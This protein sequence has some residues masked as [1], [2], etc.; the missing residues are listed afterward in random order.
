MAVGQFFR[1]VASRIP[2]PRAILRKAGGTDQPDARPAAAQGSTAT[3]KTALSITLA[4]ILC[5]MPASA[6]K[7]PPPSPQS[8]GRWS[9]GMNQGVIEA[10][11]AAPD[12]SRLSFTC[13]AG[14]EHPVAGIAVE[15]RGQ[16]PPGIAVLRLRLDGRSLPL[17]LEEGVGLAYGPMR[18]AVTEAADALVTSRARSVL[19]EL[20]DLDWRQDFPL[21]GVR[22]ALG[23]RPGPTIVDHCGG[24]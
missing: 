2:Y 12:G 22:E 16:V 14:Q 18:R 9:S 23:A 10:S 15:I 8:G 1:H 20:P 3:V 19:A 7:P 11:V 21:A 24:G 17:L 5:G 4:I 13:S 6:Q